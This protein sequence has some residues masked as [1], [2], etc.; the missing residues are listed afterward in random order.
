TVRLRAQVPAGHKIAA[1][2]I[3]QGEAIRKYDTIIGRAARDIAAGE[4]VHTHNVEL[5]DYARDP[6]FGLDVRPVDYIP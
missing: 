5:I 2:R 4:H 1:R 3:A 6:G